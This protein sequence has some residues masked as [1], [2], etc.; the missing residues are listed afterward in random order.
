MKKQENGRDV[1]LKKHSVTRCAYTHPIP[2]FSLALANT[3][4]VTRNRGVGKSLAFCRVEMRRHFGDLV[5]R[6]KCGFSVEV[7]ALRVMW[8]RLLLLPHLRGSCYN[9]LVI[10]T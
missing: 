8:G 7:E 1:K 2:V 3:K 10:T 9:C 4:P 6:L 5:R